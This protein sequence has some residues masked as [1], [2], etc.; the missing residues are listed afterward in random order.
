MPADATQ[1]S[2]DGAHLTI[3]DL[4]AGMQDVDLSGIDDKRLMETCGRVVEKFVRMVGVREVC[5]NK[6]PP[7]L[8]ND[9]VAR[10]C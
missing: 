2:P 4:A 5:F 9:G 6:A 8:H 10:W 7:C 3:H 1:L